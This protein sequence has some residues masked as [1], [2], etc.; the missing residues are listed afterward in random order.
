M[1]STRE[2]HIVNGKLAVNVKAMD[3]YT[4]ITAYEALLNDSVIRPHREALQNCDLNTYSEP[5]LIF[6]KDRSEASRQELLNSIPLAS[7]IEQRGQKIIDRGEIVDET[8]YSIIE[9]FRKEFDRRHS[10]VD[11]LM[12]TILGQALYVFILIL[13]G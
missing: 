3:V 12:T 8:T 2:I 9:S 10:T 11:E 5:N 7:G 4:V 13:K 6:D 1:D